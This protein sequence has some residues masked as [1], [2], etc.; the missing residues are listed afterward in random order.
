MYQKYNSFIKGKT[1]IFIS[2]RLSSTV[3]CDRIIFLKA[4]K[5]IE[6]GSH[7]ELIRLKGEYAN[8]YELQAYYYQEEVEADVC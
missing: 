8:M 4:G 6:D 7:E 1:S 3:F 5:I 2:H